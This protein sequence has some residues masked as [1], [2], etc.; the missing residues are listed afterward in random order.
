MP[1]KRTAKTTRNGAAA[2]AATPPSTPASSLIKTIGAEVNLTPSDASTLEKSADPLAEAHTRYGRFMDAYE[3]AVSEM[4]REKARI[5]AQRQGLR[6]EVLRAKAN[7][8]AA[9]RAVSTKYSGVDMSAESAQS[10]SY[11]GHGTLK[12]T[13]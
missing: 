9:I 10:W 6:A 2:Q 4:D 3:T 11:D 7:Y 13:A 5:D 1:T 12:R 8:E